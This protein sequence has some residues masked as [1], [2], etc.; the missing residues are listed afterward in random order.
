MSIGDVNSSE[1]GSG[2]RYNDGKPAVDLIPL[3]MIAGSF[4]PDQGFFDE[5]DKELAIDVMYFLGMYQETGDTQHLDRA[6]SWMVEYWGDCARVFDYGRKKYAAWNWAK[7]M[8]WSVPLACAGRHLIE[9]LRGNPHDDESGEL[10][11]GHV[12]CNVVMLRLFADTYPEGNDLPP[13]GLLSIAVDAGKALDMVSM[14]PPALPGD[15]WREWG[16]GQ[17][18]VADEVKVDVVLKY[19]KLEM[20][21]V[22]AESLRW[23]HDGVGSD[24]VAWRPAEG[25]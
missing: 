25:A 10:H 5:D 16:G 18:P 4:L 22:A 12:M 23:S 9:I 14:D 8:P 6:L 7:G 24:I 1:R 21:G 20:N 11:F 15:G 3:R 17:Q 2:A 13:P 19:K